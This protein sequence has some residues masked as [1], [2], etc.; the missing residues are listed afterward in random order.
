M[1]N[2]INMLNNI[3]VVFMLVVFLYRDKLNHSL[4]N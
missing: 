2:I 3:C 1:E 4:I